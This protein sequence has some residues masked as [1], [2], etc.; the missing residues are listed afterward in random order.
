MDNY[1][2]KIISQYP[3]FIV[4]LTKLPIDTQAADIYNL[5]S[6]FEIKSIEMM[7]YDPL[8]ENSINGHAFVEFENRKELLSAVKIAK[9]EINGINIKIDIPLDKIR[10]SSMQNP[11]VEKS[12]MNT[13]LKTNL[14]KFG[15]IAKSLFY[16]TPLQESS[17]FN[18]SNAAAIKDKTNDGNMLG[19]SLTKSNQTSI[20]SN[21]DNTIMTSEKKDT[22][23]NFNIS[24]DA[25][26]DMLT[27][28]KDGK[29]NNIESNND[30]DDNKNENTEE[31]ARMGLSQIHTEFVETNLNIDNN[32][33]LTNNNLDVET[34]PKPPYIVE[35]TNLP[36]NT[37]PAHI[38]RLFSEYEINSIDIPRKN[39]S[40]IGHS[41][42]E[43][44]NYIDFIAAVNMHEPKINDNVIIITI[45]NS[46]K[47]TTEKEI[48][49]NVL[50]DDK[51]SVL[52]SDETLPE[53]PSN[54][55]NLLL[56]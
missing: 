48:I 3:P 35:I 17:K 44:E 34:F 47:F 32:V 56:I 11:T 43:F 46:D 38:F 14:I 24:N 36:M 20:T 37:K 50:K 26:L 52:L 10:S 39:N 9:P 2:E 42:V 33:T 19:N 23:N 8:N 4:H 7:A 25:D 22:T 27:L 30:V 41:I 29:F 28:S 6:Q 49:E 54:K 15:A 18:N 1:N 5:F 45:F 12:K 55:I 53:S 16:Q 31:E 51:P 40:I 13:L 21:T